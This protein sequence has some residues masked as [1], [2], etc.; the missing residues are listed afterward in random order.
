LE[1]HSKSNF[2]LLVLFREM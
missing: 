2:G 1:L